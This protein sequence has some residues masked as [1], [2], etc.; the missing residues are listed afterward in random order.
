MPYPVDTQLGIH[1]VRLFS[2]DVQVFRARRLKDYGFRI[3]LDFG[4]KASLLDLFFGDGE[5]EPGIATLTVPG[6]VGSV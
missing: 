2:T 5:S 6:L 3:S 4:C 1:W